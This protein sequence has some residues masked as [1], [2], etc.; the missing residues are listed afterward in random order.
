VPALLTPRILALALPRLHPTRVSP[1][2]GAGAGH[3]GGGGGSGGARQRWVA[4]AVAA[5]HQW[6]E[7]AGIMEAAPF[8]WWGGL[9]FGGYYGGYG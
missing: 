8:L 1:K 4:G 3:Y 5:V 9:G 2:K 7:A 6:E